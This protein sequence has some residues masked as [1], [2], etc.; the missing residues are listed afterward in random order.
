MDDEAEQFTKGLPELLEKAKSVILE[1]LKDVWT[2]SFT[3]LQ[4][5]A[6]KLANE[7]KSP[8]FFAKGKQLLGMIA[9]ADVMKEESVNAIR[10]LQN[11]GLYVVML[12]GDNE[13]TAKAIV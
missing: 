7:G 6:E 1:Q 8:L 13:R 12:T 11:M 4:Q 3:H 9:V 5:I 10:Q 2:S